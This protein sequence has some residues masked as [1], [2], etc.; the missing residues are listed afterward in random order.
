[1]SRRRSAIAFAAALLLARHAEAHLAPA[2]RI[3]ARVAGSW[4]AAIG[5]LLL[6]WAFRTRGAVSPLP[7][8]LVR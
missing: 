2:A 1:M 7:G 5:L 8:I 6:G 3:A 4:V